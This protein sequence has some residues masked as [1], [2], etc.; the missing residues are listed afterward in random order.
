MIFWNPI[1]GTT[2]RAFRYHHYCEHFV[3]TDPLFALFPL[4]SVC[5][6]SLSLFTIYSIVS[7]LARRHELHIYHSFAGR[8][9]VYAI[10]WL[11]RQIFFV[12]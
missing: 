12:M 6:Y 9:C 3:R 11:L 1:P 7:L 2:G 5:R 4:H 8:S 10:R